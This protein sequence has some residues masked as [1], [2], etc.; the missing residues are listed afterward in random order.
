[1]LRFEPAINLGRREHLSHVSRKSSH[2]SIVVIVIVI[3]VIVIV[4]IVIVIIVVVIVIVVIVI[5]I[6]VIPQICGLRE[7][8]CGRPI[9]VRRVLLFVELILY[10]YCYCY[11]CHCIVGCV[12]ALPEFFA[13]WFVSDR[14]LLVHPRRACH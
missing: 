4:V 13:V 7:A 11:C 14:F 12:C 1:M 8:T 5:V 6:V 10:C 2:T 3:V 9:M